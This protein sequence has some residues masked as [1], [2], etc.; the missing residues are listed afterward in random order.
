MHMIIDCMRLC[1]AWAKGVGFSSGSGFRRSSNSE[2]PVWDARQ[3]AAVQ[4]VED[5]QRS[6]LLW[7]LADSVQQHTGAAS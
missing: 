3:S 7:V 6:S 2:S 5:A 4:Q 1:R